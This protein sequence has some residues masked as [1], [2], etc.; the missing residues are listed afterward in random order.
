MRTSISPRGAQTPPVQDLITSYVHAC[1]GRGVKPTSE[2]RNTAANRV[3]KLLGEGKPATLVAQA[4]DRCAQSN[5]H[6]KNL[7]HVV[8]DLEAEAAAPAA[9]PDEPA[10][11][12]ADC[13]RCRNYRHVLKDEDQP[14]LGVVPCPDCSTPIFDRAQSHAGDVPDALRPAS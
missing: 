11:K 7:A 8:A 6:P 3:S 4:L 14:D 1:N 5:K 9:L 13:P 10:P 2:W 12:R